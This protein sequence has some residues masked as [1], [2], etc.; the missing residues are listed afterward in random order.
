M[1]NPRVH[2][3]NR[4]KHTLSASSGLPRSIKRLCL[5]NDEPQSETQDYNTRLKNWKSRRPAQ[6]E[7]SSVALFARKARHAGEDNTLRW[8]FYTDVATYTSC[9]LY[10]TSSGPWYRV[11]RDQNTTAYR[12]SSHHHPIPLDQRESNRTSKG[13]AGR[14]S[15]STNQIIPIRPRRHR[16]Q[17]SHPR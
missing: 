7:S 6:F 8:I 16:P 10:P 13:L 15:R 5:Q 2:G 12:G 17:P 9:T 3:A 4:K 11:A 14:R 1:R